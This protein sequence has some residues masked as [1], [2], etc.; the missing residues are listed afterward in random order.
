M[1]SVE[2]EVAYKL[3]EERFEGGK[4]KAEAGFSF[5]F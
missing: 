2:V 4:K 3:V 1:S 5:L